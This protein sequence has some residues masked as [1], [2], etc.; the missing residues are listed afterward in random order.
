MDTPAL[1]ALCELTLTNSATIPTRRPCK[2]NA[3]PKRISDRVRPDDDDD[4]DL[5]KHRCENM[6]LVRCRYQYDRITAIDQLAVASLVR[7]QTRSV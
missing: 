6:L 2:R 1:V 7:R 5:L 3:R 4:A